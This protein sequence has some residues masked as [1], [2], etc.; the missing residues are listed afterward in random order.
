MVIICTNPFRDINFKYTK[1]I[2]QKLESEGQN[3]KICPV[4]A[5]PGNA[6]IPADLIVHD[7]KTAAQ[8]CDLVVVIGGDGTL[9]N[10]TRQIKEF[11]LP[12][13]GIN[14]G[15]K[16]FLMSLESDEIDY[17]IKAAK[18]EYSLSKRMMLDVS[19]VRDGKEILS[20]CALNDVVIH[21]Y[22]DCINVNASTCGT[23]VTEFSGD[24]IIIATPTGSTGYSLSAG[25]PIA[26]PESENI[27]ISPICAHMIG[28][29]SHVLSPNRVITVNTNIVYTRRAFLSVDGNPVADIQ[30]GD[31][32]T[33]KRS[34]HYTNIVELGVRSFYETTL[35][36][37]VNL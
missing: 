11:S 16:G 28:A 24:G 15:T 25:G 23:T 8:S 19:L 32:V 36:K 34:A 5:D 4:F 13:L 9:L 7:I 27:I 6:A 22:G 21:G 18:G 37:L 10:V 31:K 30:N 14:L 3:V 17:I 29:R 2:K 35:G 33:V 26:E 20:D 12:I 1:T